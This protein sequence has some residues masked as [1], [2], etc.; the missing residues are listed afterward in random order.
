V[1]T[2]EAAV[3]ADD[4][5][6]WHTWATKLKG[7]QIILHDW[8]E[9]PICKGEIGVPAH[10]AMKWLIELPKAS[11]KKL[12]NLLLL[13]VVDHIVSSSRPTLFFILLPHFRKS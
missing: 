12:D 9:V 6:G 1:L 3:I 4:G 10:R 7:V 2:E 11:V 8:R 5:H 13:D